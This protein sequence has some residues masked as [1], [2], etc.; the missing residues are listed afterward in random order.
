LQ[1]DLTG[2]ERPKAIQLPALILQS[3]AGQY[4]VPGR[5]PIR[6][7]ADE[8]GLWLELG[9]SAKHRLLPLSKAEFFD[10]DSPTVRHHFAKDAK[11]QITMTVT[12]LGPQPLTATMVR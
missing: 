5:F 12:G 7:S 2:Q 6:I 8:Q 3:F 11:G 9:P 4:S 10:E 1:G